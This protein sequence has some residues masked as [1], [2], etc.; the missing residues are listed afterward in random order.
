M[1]DEFLDRDLNWD[2]VSRLK[3]QKR[4]DAFV[5]TQRRSMEDERLSGV[6]AEYGD[7]A[8]DIF[9]ERWSYGMRGKR[10]GR[11]AVESE[12]LVNVV[13]TLAAAHPQKRIV[14]LNP[15]SATHPG[16][17]VCIGA[18]GEEESFCLCSNLYP[19][20]TTET[21]WKKFYMKHLGSG[22]I[23]VRAAAPDGANDWICSRNI[24]IFKEI[25]D[26]VP[27]LLP[28]NAWRKVDVITF[29][30]PVLD[31]DCL[32][33]GANPSLIREV[34]YSLHFLRGRNIFE[35][36]LDREMWSEY[37]SDRK[38]TDILVLPA[39]GC[40]YR[41]NPPDVVAEA[42]AALLK[43]YAGYFETVVFAA[44]EHSTVFREI[45]E[46]KGLSL[47]VLDEMQGV[48]REP[49][50]PE[51]D[52]WADTSEQDLEKKILSKIESHADEVAL[53]GNEKFTDLTCSL[54]TVGCSIEALVNLKG[55]YAAGIF[56]DGIPFIAE[57]VYAQEAGDEG[58]K[59]LKSRQMFLMFYMRTIAAYEKPWEKANDEKERIVEPLLPSQK[60]LEERIFGSNMELLEISEDMQKFESYVR[61]LVG[62]GVLE[63]PSRRYRGALQYM[64]DPWGGSFV[65]VMVALGDGEE[66]YTYPYIGTFDFGVW[67]YKERRKRAEKTK[68]TAAESGEK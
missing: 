59:R 50:T 14:A 55:Q 16:G 52:L 37:G 41:H 66:F 8:R 48:R 60:I 47:H 20:L 29:A 45:L 44:G 23:N 67:Q 38:E 54:L 63:S 56:D 31:D 40:D 13:H 22:S 51:L 19:T 62:Q 42:Y 12:P 24:T 28:E 27:C 1:M 30:P 2:P 6:R 61:Y 49:Q 11:I 36:A 64:T 34:L 4:R 35:V 39:F 21:I 7:D 57:I 33:H 5:D 26:G 17:N 9:L 18:E 3:L 53:V 65:C 10:P 68:E 58:S 32:R 46:K 43:H 15:G 25:R